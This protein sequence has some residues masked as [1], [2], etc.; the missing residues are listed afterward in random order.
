MWLLTYLLRAAHGKAAAA[1]RLYC[2][3]R[4][5]IQ[6]ASRHLE[7]KHRQM[8]SCAMRMNASMTLH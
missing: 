8:F 4:S 5:G 6:G 2:L 3:R 7:G 1:M